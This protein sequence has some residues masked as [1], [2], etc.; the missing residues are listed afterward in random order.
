MT[1]WKLHL[2]GPIKILIDYQPIFHI[3]LHVSL[4]MTLTL[5]NNI[6]NGSYAYYNHEKDV[7]HKVS[8]QY[9]RHIYI[10]LPIAQDTGQFIIIDAQQHWY[11]LRHIGF[12]QIV[13]N[14]ALFITVFSLT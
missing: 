5:N 1:K 8:V 2:V 9:S 4:K 6:I 7:L 3:G 11:F 13:N 10:G 12:M 14:A